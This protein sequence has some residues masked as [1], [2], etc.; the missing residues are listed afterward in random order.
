[1][2]FLVHLLHVNV[3]CSYSNAPQKQQ[4]NRMTLLEFH[5]FFS[6]FSLISFE[7]ISHVDAGLKSRGKFPKFMAKVIKVTMHY[8]AYKC[9]V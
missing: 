3:K 7:T 5:F 4:I 1:M 8:H 2:F 9:D 6:I